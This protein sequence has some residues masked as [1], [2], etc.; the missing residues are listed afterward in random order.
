M[1]PTQ[2]IVNKFLLN[3]PYLV[4]DFEDNASSIFKRATIFVRARVGRMTHKRTNE[5]EMTSIQF[6]AI[7]TFKETAI[8]SCWRVDSF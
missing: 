2:I 5:K 1:I 8:R 3:I 6:D 4:V 7:E